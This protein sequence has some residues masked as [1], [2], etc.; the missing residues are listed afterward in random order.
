MSSVCVAT[1]QPPTC[2]SYVCGYVR[3]G[4][5]VAEQV[6]HWGHERAHNAAACSFLP[7]VIFPIHWQW[8][9]TY[10]VGIEYARSVMWLI[11]GRR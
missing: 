5:V 3:L 4:M 9:Y 1:F 7:K 8:K 6:L 11:W 2:T 10:Q